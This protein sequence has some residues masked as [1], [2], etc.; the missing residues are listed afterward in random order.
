MKRYVCLLLLLV[1][2]LNAKANPVD[3]NAAREVGAKYLY[4]KALL[5]SANPA[6]LRLV[7][8]YRT[9]NNDTAFYVFNTD[10]GFVI[11]SANDC[12]TPILGYSNEGIF[13]GYDVPIQMEAYLQC[14]VKQ[15]QYGIENHLVADETI[16]RQWELVRTKGFI[17]DEKDTSAVAPLLT[18]FW[19]QNCYYNN[20]CPAD[21]IGP[22]GHVYTGC[23]ATSFA[24]ILHY[25]GFPEKGT[26]SHTYTPEGYPQQT[27]DFGATT[28]QWEQMPDSL[29]ES[30]TSEQINA[31]ATL[32]WHCGVAV[33]MA[34]SPHGSGAA[35]LFVVPALI[36]YFNYSTDATFVYRD[37]YNTTEWLTLIKNNL[38]LGR[39]VHYS[40]AD[41]NNNGAHAFVCDGYDDN[42]Y[43]HFNWGWGGRYN[44]YFADGALNPHNYAFNIINSA[45]INI[46]PKDVF[47]INITANPSNGGIVSFGEKDDNATYYEGQSCTVI[48]TPYSG[49]G[50]T[51]WT[52]DG[53]VVSTSANYTFTV[54]G[55]R[56]LV[57]NFTEGQLPQHTITIS[58]TPAIGGS[59]SFDDKNARETYYF[60][61]DDGT[62]MGWTSIDADGD[63]Y[64]WVSSANLYPYLYT[65]FDGAGHN[66]SQGFVCSGSIANYF[67]VLTP[68]NYL[69]SPAKG[70]YSR[71]SFFACAQD[72]RF[73]AEHF[74][75]AV[76]T[77]STEASKFTTIQ[78]WTMTAKSQGNWYEYTVDLGAYSGQDI[79]VAIRHFNCTNQYFLNIDDIALTTGCSASFTEGTPCT[80]TAMPNTGYSFANWTKNGNVVSSDNPFTFEVTEGADYEAIFGPQTLTVNL[81]ADPP[82]GGVVSG[83]GSY[84]YGETVNVKVT[85]NEDFKFNGWFEDGMF[86][87]SSSSYYFIVK[88]DRH[89]VAHLSHN[90]ALNEQDDTD[91]VIFPNPTNDKLTL[92]SEE[93][94]LRYSI[95][96]IHGSVVTQMSNI[97][98]K[99]L[100]IDIRLLPTGTYM[101]CVTIGDTVLTKKFRKR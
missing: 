53:I 48:A 80:M 31:V 60:D 76:S 70:K 47:E 16:A 23:V 18:D 50:F 40:G 34:Y 61:F 6:H 44:N 91:I 77:T 28:Y 38:D 75:V 58:A 5:R 99:N 2:I 96:D 52:E 54:N 79:W 13:S 59:V 73:P 1:A 68:D 21:T 89:F 22:C 26:G 92:K 85:P 36:N 27:A 62:T 95:Y 55:N 78:E 69:V 8:T 11:V 64:Q 72:K 30:S 56:N 39:P 33:E 3:Q 63:G 90:N 71:I 81:E 14:F 29:Y 15:I 24:Q 43:L 41:E 19:N 7:S 20:L 17:T 87:S 10:K 9:A 49:Y 45:I 93:P 97:S 32:M 57:A 12:A 35:S 88:N 83:D 37:D 74:G 4:A 98:E 25:W 42:D 101:I 66:A 94:I 46:H 67:D 65:N 51:S 82:E 86:V 100:E 84:I